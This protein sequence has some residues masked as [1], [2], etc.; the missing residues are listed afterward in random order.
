MLQVLSD[1][2]G[3]GV[4]YLSVLRETL[5]ILQMEQGCQ[6]VFCS[7]TCQCIANVLVFALDQISVDYINRFETSGTLESCSHVL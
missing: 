2:T 4:N 1:N 3:T 5:Q 7:D 6:V